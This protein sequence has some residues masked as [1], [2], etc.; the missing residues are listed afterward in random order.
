MRRSAPYLICICFCVLATGMTLT[1]LAHEVVRS[2]YSM[3]DRSAETATANVDRVRRFYAAAA[4]VLATGDG[5]L[6]DAMVAP[7]LTEHPARPGAASGREGY[8]RALLALRATFPGLTLVVDDVRAAGADQVLA[9]VHAEGTGSANFLGRPAP[10]FLGQWGPLEVW[11][12]VDGQL[13]ERWG[14]SDPAMLLPFGQASIAVDALGPGRRRVTVTRLIVEPGATLQVDNGQA[15]RLFAVDSGTLT[16]DVGTRSGGTIAVARGLALPVVNAPGASIAAV[17]GDRIVTAPE[18]DYT[19]ANEG[20]I[21]LATLVVVIFN[22]VD[23]E[24]PLNGAAAA[25]SWSVASMPEALGGVLPPP[26]GFSARVLAPGVEVDMPAQPILALGWMFLG[27]GATLGLP[28]G[29]GTLLAAVDEG[30]VELTVAD[31]TPGETLSSG[32]W[33]LVLDGAGSVWQTGVA[34]PATILMLT[35]AQEVITP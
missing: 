22:T 27:P 24:W 35:V 31:G 3:H 9:R 7:D 28:A 4:A 33:T 23:G 1:A 15:I 16:V 12:L 19:L 5:A 26:A 32:E 30:R 25:A 17:A 2:P 20:P 6:L 21:P 8:V 14:G 13:V 11:R 29:D 10:A 18:A 34:T